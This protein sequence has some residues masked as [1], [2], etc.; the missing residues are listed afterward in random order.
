M[1]KFEKVVAAIKELCQE[2]DVVLV[3]TCENEG[4]YGEIIV[5]DRESSKSMDSRMF[6]NFE[7]RTDT[8]HGN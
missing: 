8:H 7:D 3:G 6:F 1:N 4:I 5:V 2:H